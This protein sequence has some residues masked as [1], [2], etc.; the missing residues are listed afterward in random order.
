MVAITVILAAVIAPFMFSM[1]GSLKKQ[2]LVAATA[3]QQG[4]TITA[5]FNGGPDADQ[6]DHLNA[7][8][9][10]SS[11][12]TEFASNSTGSI[13]TTEG[14]DGYND[15]VIVVATFNDGTSQIILNTFV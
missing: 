5:V 8:I 12:D 9:G 1:V 11:F 15:H 10:N 6:V 7:R 4:T 2:Y 13:A 3:S 14:S